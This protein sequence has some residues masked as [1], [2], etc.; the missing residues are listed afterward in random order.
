MFD[1]LVLILLG[2][3]LTLTGLLMVTNLQVEW[4]KPLMGFSAL[5]AGLICLVRAFASPG[6]H[7]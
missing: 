6:P 1:R 7:A 2:V 4:S 5:A 3:F